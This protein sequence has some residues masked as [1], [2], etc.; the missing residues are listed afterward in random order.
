M[1]APRLLV[2]VAGLLGDPPPRVE[3]LG[4]A[5]R[6]VFEG[7]PQRAQRVHVLDLDLGAEALGAG[8]TQRDVGV[9]AQRPL[10]HLHV[11]DADRL[12]QRPQL[13]H[14]GPGLL[15]VADVGATHDLHEGH[16]GPVVVDQAVLGPVDAA[17]GP[18]HVHGL[19]DV[20][21]QVGPL[22]PDSAGCLSGDTPN[23]GD[24]QPAVDADGL[25]VLAD[26]VVL[27][28]V[29]IEVVLPVEDR[30][31]RHPAV[32]RLPH[33]QGELHRPLVEDG[34]RPGQPQA[35]RADVGVGLGSELVDA[36]AEEL[37]I[38]GQLDV[39]LEPDDRLP[40][41]GRIGN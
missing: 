23:P 12:E 35:H 40:V 8:G 6:L 38:G 24:L 31:F 18:A 27:G 21:L 33:P 32:Q 36:G 28:H 20:L 9:D 5:A 13:A 41:D 15:G 16:P 4:L 7:P 26:L 11:G 3:D 25:V 34:K 37:G 30:L 19:A 39:D 29:R 22:D 17:G 10:L 2:P 1:G 14:V